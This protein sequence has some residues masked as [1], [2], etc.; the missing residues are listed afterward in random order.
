L[1][2]PSREVQDSW[3]DVFWPVNQGREDHIS[4]FGSL[5]D[6]FYAISKAQESYK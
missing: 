4:G 5:H 1:I 2:K 3:A 6:C